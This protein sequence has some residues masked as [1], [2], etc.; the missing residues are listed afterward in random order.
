MF[1]NQIYIT[2]ANDARGNVD[3]SCE[4]RHKSFIG[5]KMIALRDIQNGD[6]VIYAFCNNMMH[7]LEGSSIM[8]LTQLFE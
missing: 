4:S 6:D 3:T 1:R 2:T 8:L 7:M 5:N